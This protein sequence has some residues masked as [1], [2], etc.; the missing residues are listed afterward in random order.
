MTDEEIAAKRATQKYVYDRQLHKYVQAQWWKDAKLA[1]AKE[2]QAKKDRYKKWHELIAESKKIKEER[3]QAA[4]SKDWAQYKVLDAALTK[5]KAKILLAR[6][7]PD[8]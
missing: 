2:K 8:E 6:M 7:E 1:K 5:I 3:D 4:N